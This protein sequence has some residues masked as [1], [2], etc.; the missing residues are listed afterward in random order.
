MLENLGT[1]LNSGDYW[2]SWSNPFGIENKGINI[3]GIV[4][5][6]FAR[7]CVLPF[8]EMGVL[9]YMASV[10]NKKPE[11][12]TATDQTVN[13]TAQRH[14]EG[15]HAIGEESINRNPS[16]SVLTA[17]IPQPPPT[18]PKEIS[19]PKK[20]QLDFVSLKTMLRPFRFSSNATQSKITL[21]QFSTLLNLE[22]NDT[23]VINKKEY[24]IG[25]KRTPKIFD[26]RDASLSFSVRDGTQDPFNLTIEDMDGNRYVFSLIQKNPNS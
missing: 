11:D 18:P 23:V 2:K 9:C 13:T 3:V 6:D 25:E 26:D 21:D 20:V 5:I 22:A 10:T 8:S 4:L 12:Q 1:N 7:I 17:T 15:G 19:P 16:G 24:L 14:F